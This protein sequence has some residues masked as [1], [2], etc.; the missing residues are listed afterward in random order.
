MGD[1]SKAAFRL[2]VGKLRLPD[3]LPASDACFVDGEMR[4]VIQ[5]Q[6][7]RDRFCVRWDTIING[8]QY[9]VMKWTSADDRMDA[10]EFA[11]R[12]RESTRICLIDLAKTGVELEAKIAQFAGHLT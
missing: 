10:A 7:N 2:S 9:M 5:Y 6:I 4:E 12:E 8:W 1:G 11:K 3:G